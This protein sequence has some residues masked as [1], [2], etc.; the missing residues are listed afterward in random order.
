M[1]KSN[2]KLMLRIFTGLL[3]IVFGIMYYFKE[4]VFSFINS[5][6]LVVDITKLLALV[7]IVLGA[8]CI[9]KYCRSGNKI[10]LPV[11]VFLVYYGIIQMFFAPSPGMMASMFFIV[12]GITLLVFNIS[13][14]KKSYLC[15]GMFLLL[16]GI[17]IVSDACLNFAL[18]DNIMFSF[19]LAIFI[20]FFIGK[21][22]KFLLIAGIF[23]MVFSLKGLLAIQ[24]VANIVISALLVLLGIFIVVKSVIEGVKKNG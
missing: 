12:P 3:L 9:Y 24:G 5:L 14:H 21:R 22:N 7:P 10:I 18:V 6:L 15:T 23:V 8:F 4:S 13:S 19:G 16:V 11:G 2:E 20:Q 1:D 17:G